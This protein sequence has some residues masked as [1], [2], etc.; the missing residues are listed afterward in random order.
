MSVLEFRNYIEKLKLENKKI[1]PQREII[2]EA[3]INS[4]NKHMTVDEIYENVH[5][6]Y[7]EKIGLATVYRAVQLFYNVGILERLDLD[8]GMYRYE[9][10]SESDKHMHHHLICEIC[11]EVFEVEEDLL[12]DIENV[13]EKKYRFKIDN[14][15]LKFYGRCMDCHEK[16][17][18]NTE[19]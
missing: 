2:L 18:S 7:T 15:K 12:D 9:L 10:I 1:T 17:V 4:S 8:D 11:S 14:H 6:K 16:I 5:V 19:E 13:I 3:I